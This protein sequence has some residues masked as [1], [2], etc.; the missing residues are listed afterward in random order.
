MVGGG[1]DVVGWWL[2]EDEGDGKVDKIGALVDEDVAMLKRTRV[3]EGTG[4]WSAA[5]TWGRG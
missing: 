2:G 1:E 3:K 5:A 4:R